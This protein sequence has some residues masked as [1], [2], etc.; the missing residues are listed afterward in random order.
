MGFVLPLIV[1]LASGEVLAQFQLRSDGIST[2]G[3]G[4]SSDSQKLLAVGGQ[5][6]AI[7]SSSNSNY[8]LNPGFISTINRAIS[9]AETIVWPGDT[10]NDGVANQADVLPLGLH[11]GQTGPPRPNAS[12]NWSGQPTTPWTHDVAT[13]AD[14]NGNGVVDQADVLPIGLNLGQ[15]HSSSSP[16]STNK[17]YSATSSATLRPDVAPPAPVPGQEFF[18]KIR[19]SE[20]DDLFGVSFELSYERPALLKILAVE[21]D[22]VLGSEVIFFSNV[23]SSSGKVSVGITRKAGQ[24]GASGAGS[25]VRVSAVLAPQ[26][27]NGEVINLSLQNV[28]AVNSSGQPIEMTPQSAQIVIIITDVSDG[29]GRIITDYRL[30]QNYPNPFNPSTLIQY[31]IPNSGQVTLTVYNIVGQQVR[32]L[33]NKSQTAGAYQISWDG[34]DEQGRRLS[35]GVYFYRLNAKSF[36]ETR[37]MTLVY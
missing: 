12:I 36:V 21:A 25:V 22:S 7:G 29:D 1:L 16:V 10:N 33:V 17:I 11:F 2:L 26:A 24:A 4:M 19:T 5:A 8:I 18:I 30:Y 27:Q 13:H 34:R 14:A 32:T 37:K 31:E 9:G 23:D 35:S 3:G 15:T 6:E 28:S 20:A